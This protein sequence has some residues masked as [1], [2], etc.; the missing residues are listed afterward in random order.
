[1]SQCREHMLLERRGRLRDIGLYREAM[2]NVERMGRASADVHRVKNCHA[3][4]LLE[5][6][7][8]APPPNARCGAD[9]TLM[10]SACCAAQAQGAAD[11]VQGLGGSLGDAQ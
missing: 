4:G 6:T 5:H 7:I 3:C 1:M 2:S 11:G 8:A 9:S 10:I